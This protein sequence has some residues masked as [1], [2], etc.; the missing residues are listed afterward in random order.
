MKDILSLTKIID[1]EPTILELVLT[2][3]IIL[4]TLIRQKLYLGRM[5]QPRFVSLPGP[6]V[7][8][9]KVVFHSLNT[10][11]LQEVRE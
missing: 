8:C 7:V 1:T 9:H 4:N 5:E 10:H 11:N 3:L 2:G 6:K